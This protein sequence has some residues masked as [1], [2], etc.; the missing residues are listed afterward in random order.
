M[1]SLAV[2]QM[3][4]DSCPTCGGV[5]CDHEEMRHVAEVFSFA[6]PGTM[7]EFAGI[8]RTNDTPDVLETKEPI[9]EPGRDCPIDSIPMDRFV[10]A[11][12]SGVVLERCNLC[13]GVWFDGDELKRVVE[14]LKPGVRDLMGK[15]ILEEMR[16]TE[17]MK[18]KFFA[19]TILLPLQVFGWFSSPV[20]ILSSVLYF[21]VQ[22]L[23]IDL[24]NRKGFPSSRW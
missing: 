9:H 8:L 10:Y 4:F 23:G 7:D 15:L 6:I 3:S 20:S 17:T 24:V 11:G 14:Y 21:L 13:Y 19:H 16:N 1:R 22:Y 12:E 18:A 5:W 2:A